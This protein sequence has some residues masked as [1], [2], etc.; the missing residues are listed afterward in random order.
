MNAA[1][2]LDVYW[3]FTIAVQY[4]MWIV[5]VCVID[6]EYLEMNQMHQMFIIIVMV[7]SYELADN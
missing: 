5:L 4:I 2:Y 3:I 1:V 6:C 7:M